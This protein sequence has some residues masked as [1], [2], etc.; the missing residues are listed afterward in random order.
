MCTSQKNNVYILFHCKIIKLT[1]NSIT[2]FKGAHW[3]LS[4]H[5]GSL[6]RIAS[7]R[8]KLYTII[9]TYQVK[10]QNWRKIFAQIAEKKNPNSEGAWQTRGSTVT[11]M[12][13][14]SIHLDKNE[15]SKS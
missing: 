5:K 4:Y 15:G 1:G 6:L 8:L 2:R 7:L 10:A 9:I 11:K 12:G 3:C 14:L 13:F